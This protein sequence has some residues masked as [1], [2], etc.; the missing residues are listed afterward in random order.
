MKKIILCIILS[1]CFFLAPIASAR[2]QTA[3]PGGSYQQTCTECYMSSRNGVLSCIC[4]DR[5][6]FPQ[7]TFLKLPNNCNSVENINGNLQC[8]Q[9][10]NYQPPSNPHHHHRHNNTFN[11]PGGPIWNQHDAK[12]R[13][14]SVCRKYSARWTG[15]WRTTIPGQ[16]SICQCQADKHYHY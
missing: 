11:A 7:K 4:R 2:H 16:M 9:W 6:N 13:C 5:N 8:A 3:L 14:P 10:N 15:E 1:Y 12:H